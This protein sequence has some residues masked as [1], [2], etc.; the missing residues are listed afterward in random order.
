MAYDYDIMLMGG[1]MKPEVM[2]WKSEKIYWFNGRKV[3]SK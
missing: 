2:Y 3:F 1:L